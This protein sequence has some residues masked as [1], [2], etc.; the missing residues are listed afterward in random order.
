MKNLKSKVIAVT[1]IM[2]GSMAVGC[3]PSES[4]IETADV[5]VTEAEQELTEARQE[6][7]DELIKFREQTNEVIASNERKIAEIKANRENNKSDVQK[8]YRKDIDELEA[9]NA[10]LKTRLNDYKDEGSE[11]WNSFR[12]E[13]NRDMDQLGQSLKEFSVDNEK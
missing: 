13:F 10:E 6:Y 4:K 8:E 11:K 12:E 9:K 7:S 2:V 5:K 3:G 1:I